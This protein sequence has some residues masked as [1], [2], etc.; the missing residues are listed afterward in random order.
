[1]NK[2]ILKI[3]QNL[4]R[5]SVGLKNKFYYG[6]NGPQYG[7]LI[8]ID[9]RKHDTYVSYPDRGGN[10]GKVIGGNWDLKKPQ[11]IDKLFRVQACKKHW[12]ENQSW[13]ETGIYDFMMDEIN[14]NGS[15]DGCFNMADLK[16]RYDNL[17][18]LFYQIEKYR[19]FKTQRELNPKN[20]NEAGGIFFHVDRYNNPL[21]GGGGVHR[22]T[23]SK[24]LNLE[25]IPAQLG[26]L[27]PEALQFWR[28]HQGR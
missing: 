10:S 19:S 12:E 20:F 3:K 15:V 16:K 1:V 7:E 18:K 22:F 13:E 23:I 11:S 25:K 6:K 28:E 4:Y 8:W 2:N 17:D 14:K 24:I 26:V 27:H 9:P 21:W 5:H